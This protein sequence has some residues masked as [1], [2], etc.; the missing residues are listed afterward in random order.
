M[1]IAVTKQGAFRGSEGEDYTVFYG[2]PYAQAPVEERRFRAPVRSLPFAGERD[3]TRPSVRPW[4]SD[5]EPDSAVGQEFYFNKK[6]LLPFD[7]D[8]LQLHIWTP[9]K[10]AGENLPVAVWIHGGGFQKGYGTEIETDGAGFCRR[11]VILVAVEY[12]LGVF[13]FLCH[14]QLVADSPTGCGNYGLLDQV[15]ALKWVREHIKAFGG[16]PQKVTL[17]GQSAGAISVQILASSPL[18]K[19]LFRSA[20]LQSGGGCQS[21]LSAGRDLQAAQKLGEQFMKFTGLD[22]LADLRLLPAQ[23]LCRLADEFQAEAAGQMAFSP[24]VDGYLLPASMDQVIE[25]NHH[26]AVPYLIGSNADDLHAESLA[27]AL[28]RFARKSRKLGNPPVYLYHFEQIPPINQEGMYPG[29]YHSAEIWYV[30]E[31]CAR[32]SRPYREQD[33]RLSVKMADCWCNFVKYGNPDPQGIFGWKAYGDPGDVYRF[34]GEAENET[35]GI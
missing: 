5:P 35:N 25:D 10:T 1:K 20:V 13:G 16:D 19:G 27:Q 32:G 31:T 11:G 18:A 2:I 34:Y 22:S 15:E 6:Y 7:E 33:Y 9:A 17:I 12:R 14:P 8:S 29:A 3:C 21:P 28:V 4:M 26:A 30:F 24:V 23:A